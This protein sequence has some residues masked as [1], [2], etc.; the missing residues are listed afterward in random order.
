M[1]AWLSLLLCLPEK[2]SDFSKKG[3]LEFFTNKEVEDGVDGAMQE[4]QRS[5]Q[6][7]KALYVLPDAQV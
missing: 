3:L 4:G 2:L 5:G 1:S 7:V 6:D